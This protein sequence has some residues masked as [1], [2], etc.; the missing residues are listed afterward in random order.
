[1][2][3]IVRKLL[4]VTPPTLI[5]NAGSFQRRNAQLMAIA[6]PPSATTAAAI[7][8]KSCAF[9]KWFALDVLSICRMNEAPMIEIQTPPTAIPVE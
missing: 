2:T 4:T 5:S 1:L 3:D 6:E 8:T 7:A 9:V